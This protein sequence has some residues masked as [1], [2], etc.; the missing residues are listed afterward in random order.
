MDVL[1]IMLPTSSNLKIHM[2]IAASIQAVTE[3]IVL[4]LSK[5]ISEKYKIKNCI[6]LSIG[7]SA[8][9]KY[10]LKVVNKI[11]KNV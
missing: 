4:K 7:N 6:R 1:I 5:N 9:N 11:F 8:E 3:E 2:D 10:L